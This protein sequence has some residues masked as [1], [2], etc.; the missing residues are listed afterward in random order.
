MAARVMLVEDD[1]TVLTVTG[2]YLRAHGYDVEAFDDGARARAALRDEQPDVLVL[3]RMLPGVNGDVLCRDVRRLAPTLPIIMVTAMGAV[4]H[5]IGG[6][7][8]GA[9]DYLAKPFSLKELQLRIDSL[10][11]R[12]R[13]G[14]GTPTTI[15]VGPFLLDAVRRR[16][17]LHGEEIA[18]TGREYELLAYLLH[19][20]GRVISREEILA[21]VW[22]W[23][24]GEASTVTVHVRRLREKI[25][26]EPRFPV[27]LLTEW[28]SGYRMQ[29]A[30]S[31]TC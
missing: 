5:R 15:E 16:I 13:S 11:R 14:S 26:P 1:R 17:W 29:V 10:L 18:L 24:F 12:T 28:G 30:G 8:A 19:H 27:Y 25:E 7:E 9:D 31:T 6:L 4:E 23:S 21:E 3:D 22:G 20:P 2:D